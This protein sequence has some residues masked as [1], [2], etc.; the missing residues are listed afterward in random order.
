MDEGEVRVS[1]ELE[2]GTRLSLVEKIFVMAEDIIIKNLPDA[3]TVF[4]NVGGGMGG[5]GGSLNS[6]QIRIPLKASRKKSSAKIAGE[7]RQMLTGIPGVILRTREGQGM[8]LLRMGNADADKLEVQV[9]GYDLKTADALGAEVEKLL[10]NTEGVTD[11]QLSREKG[12]PERI[13]VI[14]RARA[15]DLKLTV[16]KISSFLET[17]MAGSSAGN[18]REGGDEYRILVKAR[19]AEFMKLKTFST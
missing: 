15:A 19:N 17:M 2:E 4:T 3:E 13:V 7:L 6:G 14:D 11:V 5:G 9:R 16:S 18:L 10:K 12:V 1:I 8:F